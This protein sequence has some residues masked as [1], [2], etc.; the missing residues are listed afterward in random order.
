MH[1]SIYSNPQKPA[2][3]HI[4]MGTRGRSLGNLPRLS[5]SRLSHLFTQQKQLA[6]CPL[7]I[8]P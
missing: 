3:V 4:D 6:A 8:M 5:Q 7:Q 2:F 1:C